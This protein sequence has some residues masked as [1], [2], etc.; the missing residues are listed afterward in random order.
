MSRKNLLSWKETLF[1]FLTWRLSLFLVV[2]FGLTLLS[3]NQVDSFTNILSRVD[4][5]SV[6]SSPWLFPWANF[7][8]V[9]YLMIANFGYTFD[10]RFFPLFPIIIN[11]FH[12]PVF[13]IWQ[14]SLALFI[15]NFCFLISL[16]FLNKLLLLDYTPKQGQSMVLNLLIFPTSFFFAA[17][18][19]ESL[20]L[21]LLVLSFYLA[22]QKKWFWASIA[23]LLLSVT[24]P[25]GILILPALIVEYLIQQN[26]TNIRPLSFADFKKIWTVFLIPLGFIAW[27]IF[28][29][30]KWGDFF[31]FLHSQGELNN[32]RSTQSVVFFHQTIWRYLK[33]LTLTSTSQFEWWVA[34]LEIGCFVFGVVMI[35]LAWKQKVRKSY[36]FFAILAFLMPTLTGTFS[37]LPR[38]LI[39]LF[40][41]FIAITLVKNAFFRR[42]YL[43]ISTI[44]LIVLLTFFARG[45]YIS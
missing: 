33:I 44:L 37:G 32:G 25:V 39:V 10:G 26:F 9:H 17:I 20:F 30:I 42:C 35:F 23:A 21:L 24:R 14:F 31:Y 1:I 4:A 29:Y 18:Y 15:S 5:N 13:S 34:F 3:Y 6:I 7:D 22:R 16:I 12:L 36:V 2:F 41:I 19:S 11:V 45:Y 43:F 38:Y 40:P 8:G 28:N 27:S